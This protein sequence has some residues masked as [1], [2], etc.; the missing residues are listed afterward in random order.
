M[1]K[2]FNKKSE[3]EKRRL[4]RNNMPPAEWI[5]WKK[6]NNKQLSGYKFRRQY[7]IKQ[8]VIDF[9]CPELKLAIEIDGDSH[10][11]A[12][13]YDNNRQKYI[14]SFGIKF[15]RFTNLEIYENLDKVVEEIKKCL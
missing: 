9:Y 3:T 14:E 10:I 15:L 13:E 2:L 1:T 8:F 12:M 5:L 11:D 7:S 6:I 4:L